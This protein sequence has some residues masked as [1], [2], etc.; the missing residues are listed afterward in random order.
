MDCGGSD[1]HSQAVG[2]FVFFLADV[3]LS[4]AWSTCDP[5]TTSRF[6]HAVCAAGGHMFAGSPSLPFQD[7]CLRGSL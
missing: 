3:C 4:N 1:E 6:D 7:A 2:C 5:M